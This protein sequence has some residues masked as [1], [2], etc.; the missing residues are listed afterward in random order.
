MSDNIIPK[1]S[2]IVPVYNVEKYLPRCIDSILAQTFTDFELL[3]IDDGSPD[4]SGMICDEY[5][6]KDERIRV[7][8]KMNG[9]V[10][11]ARNLGLDCAKGEWICFIDSD[12]WVDDSYLENFIRQ[13]SP[14][15]DL[16]LQSFWIHVEDTQSVQTVLLPDMT[17][18]GNDRL[19]RWL[20]DAKGVHNG[21]IWH[22]LFKAEIIREEHIRFIEGVSFAEDGWFFFQYLKRQH[23]FKLTSQIGYHYGVRSGSLTSTGRNVPLETHQRVITGYITSLYDFEVSDDAK[24]SHIN[25][26]R[27][28]V[29]RLSES[30]FVWRSVKDASQKLKCYSILENLMDEYAIHQVTNIPFTLSC[31]IG[32]IRMKNKAMKDFLLPIILFIR[33]Y[34]QKIKRHL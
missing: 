24:A 34:E 11:S 9:G 15:T 21:F 27:K 10:S 22:R 14:D 32:T 13:L 23:C 1:I 29:W 5:A 25:F 33:D 26:V 4:N 3:L 16:V 18:E 19:V 20:E 6:V 2:V 17:V 30:W 7:F 28:Y 8:H 31:L 12:D